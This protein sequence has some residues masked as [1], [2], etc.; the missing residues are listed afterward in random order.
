MARG[1]AQIRLQRASLALWLPP[2][3]ATDESRELQAGHRPG[4]RI[5]LQ[6][7]AAEL[8]QDADVI[9]G[10]D[11]FCGNEN[12]QRATNLDDGAHELSLLGRLRKCG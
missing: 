9:G 5:A 8:L 6:H 12:I 10:L 7:V 2:A 4:E 3:F 1:M 11:T